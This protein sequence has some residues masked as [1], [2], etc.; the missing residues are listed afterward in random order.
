MRFVEVAGFYPAR[1]AVLPYV[2]AHH[3]NGYIDTGVEIDGIHIY[4][5][6][7]A[8]AEMARLARVIPPAVPDLTD[9]VTELEAELAQVSARRDELERQVAAVQVLKSAGYHAA[10]KPGRPPK[11]KERVSG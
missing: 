8:V 10:R 5:S 9:R 4:V 1:C 2:G 11:K 7:A 6:I 3:P